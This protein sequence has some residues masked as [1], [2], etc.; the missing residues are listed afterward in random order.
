[1]KDRARLIKIENDR[2]ITRTGNP[3][4]WRACQDALLLALK[5]QGVLDETQYR[6]GVE[7][8]KELFPP[9]GGEAN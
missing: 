8:G 6:Y 7:R 9:G 1:M 3:Q 4:F 5:D 2:E